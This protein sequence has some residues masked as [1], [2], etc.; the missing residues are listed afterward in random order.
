MLDLRLTDDIA[1]CHALRRAVFID[2]QN[3]DAALELD[4][5]DGDALH[6]L[7]RLD[8]VPV[9]CARILIAGETAKIGRVCVLHAHRGTGIGRALMRAAVEEL[10]A[11]PELRCAKLGAQTHALGFYAALGFVAT[12]PEYLEAGIAHRD[13]M[14]DLSA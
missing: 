2:E 8:G 10:R 1:A 4:G 3:V 14:L 5:R 7:A 12:G 13:M 9:G 6:V 11:R